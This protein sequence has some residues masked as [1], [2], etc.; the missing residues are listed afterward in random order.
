MNLATLGTG[1]NIST[2]KTVAVLGAGYRGWMFGEIVTEL[3]HLG[4]VVA[5][6]EPR[7]AYRVKFSQRHNLAPDHVFQTWEDFV[8][9]PR[10]CD[11]VVLSTMDRDHVDAAVA[12]LEKGY[13]VLLE[14]PMAPTLEGC[15][16]IVRAQEESRSIVAV[17]HSMRYQKGFH[18]VKELIDGGAI[19]EIV[20]IDQL[21]QVGFEHYA[22][23]YVRG[24][25][26]NEERSAPMLLAKSCH[27]L[28]YIAYLVDR[29]CRTVSS[30][31]SLTHFTAGNAPP[32][33]AERCTDG[34]RVEPSCPYS[35]IKQYVLSDLEAWPAMIVSPVHT[36]EAHL[37]A[38][39][40]GPYGRCVYRADNDVVDHQIVNLEF[41]G[42][43]TATFTM[44][45]FTQELG[46]RV[47]VHG[48][49]GE[50]SYDERTITLKT[51]ADKDVATIAIGPESGEHGGG[52]KRV[53]RNWLLA[54]HREDPS[55]ILTGV[56]ESL[57]THAI[58][59]ATER[60][61]LERR[62]VT[63]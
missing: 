36:R 17:C 1:V 18:K 61:R 41:E 20:T 33:A 44:T 43:I 59:F 22:H 14:K 4:R 19:G 5:V 37:D 12:C 63:V 13:H 24:N 48:T 46:R 27:D 57:K 25:W 7:D 47:R 21:E 8:A 16:A 50:L 39:R 52:D 58:V 42:A 2:L 62:L 32:G 56:H 53:V 23:S 55:M 10:L 11:A 34:C 6:A 3:A 51:F 28:D 54:L 49:R 35:A 26:G 15:E 30:F 9:R 40:T 60:S 31:G 29:P 45:A 38:I